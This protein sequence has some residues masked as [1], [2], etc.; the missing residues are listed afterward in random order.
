M[1]NRFLAKYV[2]NGITRTVVFNKERHTKEDAENW[3]NDHNINNFFFFFEP[4]EPKAI[5]DNTMLFQGD[6]GFDITTDIIM[7]HVNEGKDIIIDSG[8]GNHF[9]GLKIHDRIMLS[10]KNPTIGVIGICASA[11]FDI[12]MAGEKRWVSENSRGLIHNPWTYAEGDDAAFF[13]IAKD[14]QTE[15]NEV[16]KLYAKITGNSIEDI[17]ALMKEERFMT[18]KEMLDLNFITEIRTKTKNENEMTEKEKELTEKVG[19]MES[20]LNALK[21]LFTGKPQVKNLSVQDAN[22]IEINFPDIEEESQITVGLGADIDGSPASGSYVV[23]SGMHEGKT[24]VF[25]NGTLTEIIEPVE[26]TNEEMEALQAENAS[27]KEQLEIANKAY[28]DFKAKAEKDLN[29]LTAQV[30]EFKSLVTTGDETEITTPEKK[31]NK[32]RKPF[33]D[34]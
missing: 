9:E 21:N 18:P 13:S 27:L 6:V 34:K 23:G 17:L 26:E 4:I 10:G 28:N 20:V 2:Q 11:A 19:K 5:D 31:Q 8:G 16:A 30:T 7:Q 15:K 33:K 3:L 25:E 12:L 22:G 32:I 29:K 1:I 14:L 24:L